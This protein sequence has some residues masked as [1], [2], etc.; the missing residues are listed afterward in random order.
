MRTAP[1]PKAPSAIAWR[2]L[3]RT[4]ALALALISGAAAAQSP[5]TPAPRPVSADLLRHPDP[6]DWLMWRRTYDGAGFSPLAQITP[7]NVKTLRVAW[8]WSLTSGPTETTPL[9]H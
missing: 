8:T 2:A 3:G 9:V 7:D 4:L 6:A 1:L 5:P